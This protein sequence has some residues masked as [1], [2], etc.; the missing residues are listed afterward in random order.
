MARLTSGLSGTN[1]CWLDKPTSAQLL[2]YVNNLDSRSKP[3]YYESASVIELM[4]H[5]I[6]S[7]IPQPDLLPIC[8]GSRNE[9]RGCMKIAIVSHRQVNGIAHNHSLGSPNSFSDAFAFSGWLVMTPTYTNTR[10]SSY[11]II[12]LDD[13]RTSTIWLLRVGLL[14]NPSRRAINNAM[15]Q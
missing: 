5:R 7:Q 10:H 9:A 11:K 2:K 8:L 13:P 1:R 15:L 12:P 3:R 4:Y 14:I 6:P